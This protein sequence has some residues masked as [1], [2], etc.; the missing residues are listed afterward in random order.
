MRGEGGERGM[1]RVKEGKGSRELGLLRVDGSD[2][3]GF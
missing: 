1:E 2:E 3:D